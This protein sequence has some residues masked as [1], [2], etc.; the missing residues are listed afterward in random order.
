MSMI[1]R[2]VPQVPLGFGFGFRRCC[3]V[4]LPL[5]AGCAAL[6]GCQEPTGAGGGS[7]EILWQHKDRAGAMSVPYADEE[8]AV[9]NT[10]SDNRV[11]A[12]NAKDGTKRWEVR[13]T[14]PPEYRGGRT[15]GFPPGQLVGTGDVIAVP[16][17]DLYGLDKKTG[18]VRWKL[19]P[20]DDFPGVNVALGEDG[21]LYSVGHHLYRI[22]PATGAVLWRAE[23]G[24]RPFAPV[25]QGGVVYVGTRGEIP[26][27]NGILGAGHAVALDAATGRVLWKTP[28]P[29][30]EEPANGGVVGAGALTPDLY[31]VSSPNGRIYAL[32][33]KTG[34][35]RWETKGS[36]WYGAGVVVLGKVAVT[37]TW[38]GTG[39]VEGFDL[40][41]GQQQWKVEVGSSVSGSITRVGEVALVSNGR[42]QAISSEGKTLWGYGGAGWN[43]PVIST[44]AT[45]RARRIYVGTYE[46]LTAL[47][48]PE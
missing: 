27:S 21:Y 15:G 7:V 11:V 13:L 47:Q 6:A 42:L 29:A 16:A 39:L 22:D 2:I 41:T 14:L 19:A 9:F 40:A 10:I 12:L 5:L 37:A 24:E 46:G 31:V 18:Q 3:G 43:Q 35:S 28:I 4:A 30:P 48:A 26:G 20:P 32:E 34:V 33:R 1:Y 8:I 44:G 23:F 45:V 36:N 25:E 17:W 38:S